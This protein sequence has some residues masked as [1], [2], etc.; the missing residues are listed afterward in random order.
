MES[1]A[2]SADD[3]NQLGNVEGLFQACIA[4]EGQDA[5]T[6]IVPEIV[7]TQLWWNDVKTQIANDIAAVTAFLKAKDAPKKLV[8]RTRLFLSC[9]Q[10]LSRTV[11]FLPFVS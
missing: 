2:S 1:S 3:A 5:D 4:I 6:K 8:V 11:R 10:I 9:I 7:T